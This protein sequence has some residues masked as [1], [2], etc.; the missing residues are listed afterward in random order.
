[1]GNKKYLSILEEIKKH[2]GKEESNVNDKILI[3][4]GLNTFIRVFSAI[5]TTNDDGIH[6]GGIIG[7][8]KSIAYTTKMLNTTRTIIVFDGKGGSSRRRKLYP[9]YKNKRKGKIRLNRI[10]E[11]ENIEDE[12]HS[13]LMQLSRCVEYLETLPLTIVSVDNVEADDVIAYISKQLLTDSEIKI[14]STDKDFLQLVN[15]RISVWSPTKKKLYKPETLKE[16]YEITSNNFLTYRILEGDKSDNIPGVNGIG[17]KT[18]V[19]RFP[20]LLEE[21]NVS[22][23]D[24]LKIS[25]KKK[26][27]LKIYQNVL[28]SK[29]QLRLNYKLMQ[30]NNVD[31]SGSAKLKINRTVNGKIPELAKANFQKMFIEDRMYGALP[32]IDSWMR[33]SWAKLNR[34]AKI[35]NG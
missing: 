14:M 6:I 29:K 18:A 11:Y 32:D 17:I 9:E 34:F 1:M 35:N 28:D 25:N 15:N 5:P 13:M 20:Q 4:D 2:G 3:C 12:R 7:F 10:N 33:L 22:V 31:I 8:L 27:E 21:K 30:L 26:D 23:D 24:L 16:E 19:K